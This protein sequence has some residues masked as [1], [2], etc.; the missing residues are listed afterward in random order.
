[1]TD[2]LFDR[3]FRYQTMLSVFQSMLKNGLISQDDFMHAEV[4]IRMKYCPIFFAI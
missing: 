4:E 1:M 3:E 2:E